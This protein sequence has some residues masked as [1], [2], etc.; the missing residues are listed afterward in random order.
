MNTTLLFTTAV[1]IALA[2]IGYL[3]T[4]LNNLRLAQRKE[5]LERVNRQLG[6]LYGPLFA[7]TQASNRAWTAFRSK[8]RPGQAF[9]DGVTTPSED[10]LK[11]WRLWMTTIFMPANSRMYELVLSKSDLMIESR[12]P[13]CLLDL[14][15]HVASYQTVMARWEQNDYTEHVALL[16][17]PTESLTEYVSH[18]FEQLKGEQQR[19]LGQKTGTPDQY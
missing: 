5:R 9:F 3:A 19:L 10:E 8:Y 14:C 17:Y 13:T 4:Y 11:A 2:F 1:T 16:E 18:A 15:A 7:L 6:E 12:M